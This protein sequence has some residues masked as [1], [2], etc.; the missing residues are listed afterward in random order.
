MLEEILKDSIYV[1]N[2]S[3][4]VNIN[5]NKVKVFAESIKEINISHWL[6]NSPYGIL[7]LS[8]D[9]LVNFL[10][11]YT[12][13]DFS[14]WGAPKWTIDTK[15]GKED[16]AFALL[17]K[18][19]KY[20][21]EKNSTDFSKISLEDFKEILKGNVEIPLLNERYEIIKEVSNTVNIKMG[22]D[23]YI[24]TKNIKTDK[25]LFNVIIEN[26]KSF[27][28]ERVYNNKNI[29][30]Y[31]LAQLLTSD[32]L[33]IRKSKENIKVDY[34]NLK[35]CA[36]YKIPQVM[37]GL[38]ILEYNDELSKIV[39]NKNIILEN[40]SYE[41]EIRASMIVAIDMINEYLDNKFCAID[42]NDYIW[43]QGRNKHIKIK[44]YHLTRTITY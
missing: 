26:F 35:G 33:H 18:L 6:E 5:K 3:K 20:V 32:I 9:R 30:F 36:D 29:K 23:F 37:R 15:E 42:I 31:K 4:Y 17:Y 13:I 24:Y 8:I 1:S 39:N 25:E 38:G 34:S 14:F 22:G 11:I 43:G 21:K 7:D 16:G 28:D 27:K 10:L 2:N 12:S 19:L 44:P 40:S 41:V